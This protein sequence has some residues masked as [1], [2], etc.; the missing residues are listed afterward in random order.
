MYGVNE[1]GPL[2]QG[3]RTLLPKPV[4]PHRILVTDQQARLVPTFDDG[5]ACTKRSWV[6]ETLERADVDDAANAVLSAERRTS[7]GHHRD[8]R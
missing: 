2:T 3:G 4:L 5:T 7:T 1:A 6:R 8:T